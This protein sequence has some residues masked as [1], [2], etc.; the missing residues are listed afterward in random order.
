MKLIRQM[1]HAAIHLA[2]SCIE[3]PLARFYWWIAQKTA[4]ADQRREANR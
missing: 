3:Q 1:I 2:L 4:E